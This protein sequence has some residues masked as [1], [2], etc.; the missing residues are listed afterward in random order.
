MLWEFDL[1][2]NRIDEDWP[3]GRGLL[4][5]YTTQRPP[6]K[7]LDPRTVVGHWQQQLGDLPRPP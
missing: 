2:V 3:N 7:R 4:W 1:T 5:G 6:N